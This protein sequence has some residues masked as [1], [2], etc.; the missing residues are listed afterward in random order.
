MWRSGGGILGR[1]S[2]LRAEAQGRPVGARGAAGQRAP[3]P[4]DAES[5]RAP[6]RAADHR[7]RPGTARVRAEADLGR[8]LPTQVG[9]DPDLRAWGLAGASALQPEHALEAPGAR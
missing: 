4:A 9:R 2:L 1:S 7:L 5:D 8:A 3:A 6:P